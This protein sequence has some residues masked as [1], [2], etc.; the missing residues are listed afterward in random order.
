MGASFS[1]HLLKQE[2]NMGI[3]R[4]KRHKRRATGGR[5]PSL[6]KKRKFELGRPAAMT[7]LGPQRIHT[8][9]CRGGNKK[10]RALR[11]DQGNFAWG[12]EAITRKTRIIDVVYNASN[13]EAVR[14]KTLVKSCIVQVDSTPFRQW[15][16]AHYAMPLGRKKGVKLSEEDEAVLNKV[17]SKKVQ[18]KFDERK[19]SGKVEQA[20]DDQFAASKV[21]AKISS[22]PGQCGRVDGY[23][24][25][26]RELD[27]YTRKMKSK[28]SK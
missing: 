7:K 15:Y 13:N 22:R 17:R 11:L 1:K 3:S 9:R 16:E 26:G 28:K 23:I 14:T 5:R 12:S 10:Y 18:K 27:F 2:V 24:L 8:V 20:L 21:Y 4:D 6:C 19:K 25:E